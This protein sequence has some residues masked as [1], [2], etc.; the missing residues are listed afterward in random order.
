M[1]QVRCH[2]TR[3]HK[4]P[5]LSEMDLYYQTLRSV[6]ASVFQCEEDPEYFCHCSSMERQH[7]VV[8]SMYG[9]YTKDGWPGVSLKPTQ[10]HMQFSCTKNFIHVAWYWLGRK[11][12]KGEVNKLSKVLCLNKAKIN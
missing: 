11:R 2:S 5:S 7:S 10:D 4:L 12:T 9:L 8:V 3:H 6:T 1:W